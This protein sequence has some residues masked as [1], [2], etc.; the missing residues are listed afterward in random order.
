MIFFEQK[1]ISVSSLLLR[2]DYFFHN[3]IPVILFRNH[4]FIGYKV[5]GS[6]KH[7]KCISG[8]KGRQD[9]RPLLIPFFF[10][11]HA[12]LGKNLAINRLAPPLLGWRLHLADLESVTEL[13]KNRCGRKFPIL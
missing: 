10:H 1:I 9:A 5:R 3:I 4:C 7:N 2:S 12:G 13:Y 6:W 8:S 11:L